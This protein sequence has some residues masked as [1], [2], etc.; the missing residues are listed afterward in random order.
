MSVSYVA[1]LR[2]AWDRAARMLFRPFVLRTWLVLGFA[3]F[4]SEYLSGNHH[5]SS[6]NYRG[7]HGEGHRIAREIAGFLTHPVWTL[8]AICVIGLI[9]VV[10][11][12]LLWISSRGR[13]VFLDDVVHSRAAIVEPWR[14]LARLGDSLFLW[15]V[16]FSL[17]V[18]LVALSF[19]VPILVTVLSAAAGGGF[20]WERLLALGPL[21]SIGLLFA[22]VVSYVNLFLTHFVVPI[23]YRDGIGVVAG[24][25]RFL[26][27]LGQHVW[28]FLLYGLFVL[29]L[30]MAVG[31]VIATVGLMSCCVGFLLLVIPYV[32]SVILL[33]VSVPFR[34]LGPEFLAQFGEEFNVFGA[35]DSQAPAPA[36]APPGSPK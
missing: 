10:A 29:V 21:V 3:A 9:V 7:D 22:L 25:S 11:I 24:W 15:M 32:G 35:A 8:V 5:A 2:R 6:F 18:I 23:M 33:P 36:P 16:V 19:A 14:R 27:L 34:A 13:F 1:P 30:W 31:V 26:S 28:E 4:L 17:A 12:V 20:H